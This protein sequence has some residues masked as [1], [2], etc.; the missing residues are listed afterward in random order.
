MSLKEDDDL[1]TVQDSEEEIELESH[2]AKEE[3]FKALL[4]KSSE[5]VDKINA[6]TTQEHPS[7][8]IDYDYLLNDSEICDK[9]FSIN[10]VEFVKNVKRLG[11]AALQIYK[12]YHDNEELEFET[13]VRISDPM[14]AR[15]LRTISAKKVNKGVVVSTATINSI[16]KNTIAI[17]EKWG[18]CYNCNQ[19]SEYTG[20]RKC[21]NCGERDFRLKISKSKSTDYQFLEIQEMGNDSGAV[22]ISY[23]LKLYGPDLVLKFQPGDNIRFSGV[24][25][26]EKTTGPQSNNI[27]QQNDEEFSQDMLFEMVIEALH[28]EKI[29]KEN[30]KEKDKLDK[31]DIDYIRRLRADNTD[32]SLTELLVSQF[33]SHI[34]GNELIKEILLT[35]GASSLMFHVLMV[36][37]PSTGKTQLARFSSKISPIG[38]FSAGKGSSGVGLTAATIPDKSGVMKLVVGPVVLCDGGLV[39]VDE[40]DKIS[41]NDQYH[42]LEAME[43]GTVE[44][45]KGG[46]NATLNARTSITA[47]ANPI[48]GHYDE[49]KN[50]IDN[51]KIPVP[52]LTRFDLIYIMKDKPNKETD[53]QIASHIGK[54]FSRMTKA[55]DPQKQA[56]IEFLRKYFKYIKTVLPPTQDITEDVTALMDRYYPNL[57]QSGN[58][59]N[60][61]TITPRQVYGIYTIAVARSRLLLKEKVEKEDMD[62]AIHLMNEVMKT[63]GTDVVTGQV[64]M[65][66]MYKTPL[67]KLSDKLKI[68]EVV[69][70]LT[71][72]GSEA[73]PRGLIIESLVKD[74]GVPEFKAEELFR[75]LYDEGG[76]LEPKAGYFILNRG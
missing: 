13:R 19:E 62:R 23:T 12:E 68:M 4:E 36:G 40:L 52:L 67:R 5:I 37:A 61:T 2:G 53:T 66:I 45:H 59:S 39:G 70:A 72:N 41:L 49:Y 56:E 22:P 33:A 1:T 11:G 43:D 58:D 65:G 10:S 3:I 64:D 50:L 54:V 75:R 30:E 51:V 42:F 63:S 44:V 57:R 46:I 47:C 71:K 7:L 20:S 14:L 74:G 48:T 27:N 34:Y 73:V 28:V 26:L 15:P 31:K 38:M 18:I 8:V 25:K 17:V 55:N 16:S 24:V 32:R 29:G 9:Y 60:T 35:Q 76:L 21:P 6:L 69:N